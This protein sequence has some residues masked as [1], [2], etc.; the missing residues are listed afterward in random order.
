[1]PEQPG[2]AMAVDQIRTL[3]DRLLFEQGQLDPLELLL[4]AGLL[5]YEDYEA[6]RLG[7]RPDLETALVSPA[8]EVAALLA[9]AAD[10]ARR[11]GLE[12]RSVSLRGWAATDA[13]LTPGRNAALADACTTVLAPPPERHQ[14]DLFHDS[15]ALLVEDALRDALAA[16][17]VDEARAQSALLLEQAPEHPCLKDYLRLI[18]LLDDGAS[19]TITADERLADLETIEPLARERLGHR[20]RDFLAALWAEL[21]DRLAGRPFDPTAATLHASRA[22]ARAGRWDAVRRSIEAEPDW[23]RHP[24]LLLDHAEACWRRRDPASA[25]R[26]WMQLCWEHP[27]AAERALAASSFPDQQLA[28]RWNAFGDLDEPL[29]TEDFPA[30]LLL[31]DPAAA[32]LVPATDAPDDDRGEAFRILC[33]LVG[34]DDAIELRRALGELHPRLLRLYLAH[35]R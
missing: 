10:Y 29:D 12:P 31:H 16:R 3:V 21:A 1:M 22:W 30:W 4:A 23:R 25:R 24:Q 8:A 2:H 33:R 17:Q 5:A 14:L 27:E 28:G 9:E 18:A 11:Q 7:R 35:P 20:A 6:W 32:A 15:A 19:Q 13:P 34:G 26:D